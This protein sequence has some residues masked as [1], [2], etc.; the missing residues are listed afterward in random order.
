MSLA[1]VRVVDFSL[2]LPGPYAT[3]LLAD[4][5]ADV[6]R[7][8]PLA[9]DPVRHFMP[10]AYEFLNR[11]KRALRVNLKDPDG[12]AL[13]HSLL[14]TADVVLE[15]FRPGVADRLGIGFADASR[16]RS[17]VVYCSISG[18]GQTGPDRLKPGHDIGY[19]SGGGAFASVLAADEAPA[20][21]H[22]PVADLGSALFAALTISAA[23]A[24][25][26]DEPVH[27]DVSMQEAVT[28][29]AIPRVAGFLLDGE[30]PAPETLAP[31]APGSGLFRTADGRWVALA[32]VEDHFWARMCVALGREDLTSFDTHA[33]RMAR[34][35]ELRGAIADAVAG[36]SLE[37]L[38]ARLE[39]ADVP[40]DLVRGIAEVAADPHLRSRGMFRLSGT[41]F[42]VE[43][44]VRVGDDSLCR[45]RCGAGGRGWRALGAL[46][47]RG[48][49]GA[50]GR[51]AHGGCPS[52]LTPYAV[53]VRAPSMTRLVP[54]TNAASSESR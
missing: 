48:L 9:G 35:G 11:G 1:G 50:R 40:L 12:L 46:R 38:R 18:Y 29:L 53:A 23:V 24:G 39:A 3:R 20:V 28:H 41:G 54:L 21:P 34:R 6:V 43:F 27:L 14:A 26:R 19:E 44:P 7:V 5:G 22:I 10:G 37:D 45:V 32:A 30:A 17:D 36:L 15:G 42:E 16:L 49:G 51:I 52:L 25:A 31:Y 4:L 47:A 33:A 13:V 2:Y 8:E